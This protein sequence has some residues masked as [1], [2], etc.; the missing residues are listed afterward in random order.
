MVC[1]LNYVLERSARRE[2]VFFEG[3]ESSIPSGKIDRFWNPQV[4]LLRRV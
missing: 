2:S 4:G 3:K 1:V